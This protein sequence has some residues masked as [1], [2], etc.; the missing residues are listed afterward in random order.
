MS[1]EMRKEIKAIRVL[2]FSGQHVD[3][4]E[5]SENYQGI[6]AERGYLKIMLG[7]E[8]VPNDAIDIDQKVD[9]KYV[10]P[11][12]ER[13]EMHLARKM[14]QKGYRDLQL[15]TSKLAFQ[16]VSL[17]KTVD[18][19]SGSLARSWAALKDEYDESEEEDKIKLLEDFQNNKLLN[20]KVNITEWLAFLS[21]QV[22]KLNK[23][24]H[25]IDDD[26]L[27]THILASLPQEYSTV[28]DHAKIDWRN[29]ALTVIDLKKR[30]K[31]K[32]IQLRKENGWAEDEMA[33]AASQD[34]AKN[35]NTG[36]NQRKTRR[37][38]GRCCHCGKYGH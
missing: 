34:S 21:T 33:L 9:S 27:M 11:D 14:N 36:S 22:V 5:W 7:M 28:V 3:W 19:P 23:L 4:D 26:Y 1:T 30:L 8:K 16:L 2:P 35:Q 10:I 37:F 20:A 15:S 29:K 24:S 6:A 13:K 18:L 31:E 32:Y 17:A 25:Q 38:K 12:D